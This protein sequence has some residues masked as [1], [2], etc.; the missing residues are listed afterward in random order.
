M[1]PLLFLLL[2]LLLRCAVLTEGTPAVVLY[3]GTGTQAAGSGLVGG[4]HPIFRRNLL[5]YESFAGNRRERRTDLRLPSESVPHFSRNRAHLWIA[6]ARP[7][8]LHR[9]LAKWEHRLLDWADNGYR[10]VHDVVAVHGELHLR[11]LRGLFHDRD[12]GPVGRARHAQHDAVREPSRGEFRRLF[13]ELH[14]L[15]AASSPTSFIPSAGFVTQLNANLF[16]SASSRGSMF[17][18]SEVTAAPTPAGSFQTWEIVTAATGPLIVTATLIYSVASGTN[19]QRVLRIVGTDR[20]VCTV[21]SMATP[22]LSIAGLMYEGSTTALTG[23]TYSLQTDTLT[24]VNAFWGATQPAG[25]WCV[26]YA[27]SSVTNSQS[28]TLNTATLF[29]TYTTSGITTY[30]SSGSISFSTSTGLFTVTTSAIYRIDCQGLA[31]YSSPTSVN[32]QAWFFVNSISTSPQYGLRRTSRRRGR[33]PL[34]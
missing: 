11:E 9:H 15:P 12:D 13:S 3:T 17:S 10:V 18:A 32:Y 24:S 8:H 31:S 23:K 21:S 22:A 2:V 25:D 27:S 20:L 6:H 7:H 1:P 14:V 16:S 28:I 5:H 33:V 19:E 26:L 30:S 29:N 34:E 4:N